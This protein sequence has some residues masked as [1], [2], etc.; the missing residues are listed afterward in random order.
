MTSQ[1]PVIVS[2]SE[3]QEKAHTVG[4]GGS[5]GAKVAVLEGT[6]HF[7]AETQALLRSRLTA[8]AFLFATILT[9]SF[10]YYLAVGHIPLKAFRLGVLVMVC[11][12]YAVLR[13]SVTLSLR[14]LRVF[15]FLIFG[16][17]SFQ[18][19]WM[20]AARISLTLDKQDSATAV[21]V[22]GFYAAVFS[23][24]IIGYGLFVPNNGRRSA[25]VVLPFALLAYSYPFIL[26]T[27]SPRIASAFAHNRDIMLFPLPWLAALTAI[28]GSHT[29]HTIRRSAFRSRRFGQYV[30]KERI[31]AGGMGEV[32]QAEHVLLKRPC[33]IK[34]IRPDLS[35][36]ERLLTRFE[37]EVMATARLSHWN[38][39]EIFDYGRTDDGTFYY[40][41]E[42]LRG[43]TLEE[44]V[45][46]YGPLPAPRAVH[47]LRQ[48]CCA[49]REAHAAGLIHRD[50]NP[51]N[52]FA[53]ELGNVFDV[54]K[55]LDFGIVKENAGTAPGQTVEGRLCGS[56]LYMS[57]EQ[58]SN[59]ESI[60][61]RSDLYSL[62][63]VGY[64]LVTGKTPFSGETTMSLLIA[65]ARDEVVPPSSVRPDV[66][67]DFERV[68]L[69]CLSKSPAERFSD[70]G[71]LEEALAACNCAGEWTERQA[72]AWWKEFQPV[73]GKPAQLQS[74][75]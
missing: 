18:F 22:A 36:N 11:A 30:L 41:M 33:A 43:M 44:L 10:L 62:G 19:F 21:A 64:Y 6:P 31:G 32:Y 49:L 59:P 15:E 50:I 55:L 60:D 57:P 61:A 75:V 37:R 47:L 54:A 25:A 16:T 56:P 3:D 13:S 71:Q 34:L 35:I 66:P 1:Q 39:V 23:L 45:T 42:L 29:I 27:F 9:L 8:A 40:V 17:I 28:Y 73:P 7:S 24:S 67:A 2:A 5:W 51:A 46:K 26:S 53:A 48:A 68:L 4:S 72:Q 63:A 38:T 20:M 74:V 70:A 12:S 58:A 65:H 69:R 14:Q 52:L